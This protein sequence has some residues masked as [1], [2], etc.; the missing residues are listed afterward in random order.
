MLPSNFSFHEAYGKHR[1]PEELQSLEK[2]DREALIRNYQVGDPVN[3]PDS[4]A[5][6]AMRLPRESLQNR[7]ARFVY[8]LQHIFREFFANFH[9]RPH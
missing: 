4:S 2:R 3:N 5:D 9:P 8:T 6:Q 7:F 1:N